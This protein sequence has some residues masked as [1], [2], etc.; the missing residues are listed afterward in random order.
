MP[1]VD[2]EVLTDDPALVSRL[3]GPQGLVAGAAQTVNS[4]ALLIFDGPAAEG[5]ERV[6]AYAFRLEFGTPNVAAAA[7]NWLWSQLQGHA[8]ELR[9]QGQEVAVHH[10]A[11]KDALLQAAGIVQPL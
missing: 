5:E 3:A 1:A 11:I 6:A 8:V 9:V 2:L 10:A 4:G 7:A